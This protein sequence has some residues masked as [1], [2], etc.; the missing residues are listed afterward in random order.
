MKILLFRQLRVR[1]V[2]DSESG[3]AKAEALLRSVCRPRSFYK[4]MMCLVAFCLSACGP[5]SSLTGFRFHQ[6]APVKSTDWQWQEAVAIDTG[7]GN[8]VNNDT[9]NSCVLAGGGGMLNASYH[10]TGCVQQPAIAYSSQWI[11]AFPQV[12]STNSPYFSIFANTTSLVTKLFGTLADGFLNAISDTT[13][14]S[15]RYAQFAKL[16][17]GD[18]IAVFWN[19]TAANIREVFGNVYSTS[20]GTWSGAFRLSTAGIAATDFGSDGLASGTNLTALCR[21]QIAV[22]GDGSAMVAWCED[23]AIPNSQV[24]YRIYSQGAWSPI[25][26][27][28]PSAVA[29]SPTNTTLYFPGFYANTMAMTGSLAANSSTVTMSAKFFSTA[30]C[31]SVSQSCADVTYTTVVTAVSGTPAAGQF[32]LATD[33]GGSVLMCQT[34]R[35]MMGAVLG[36]QSD[37]GV[38]FS[39]LGI[40]MILDS[41]CNESATSTC[42]G[43]DKC[44]VTAYA[45]RSLDGRYLDTDNTFTAGTIQN[46]DYFFIGTA[47]SSSL[48]VVNSPFTNATAGTYLWAKSAGVAIAGDGYGNYAMARTAVSPFFKSSGITSAY[49]DYG[50]ML[51]G[52]EYA[53]GTTAAWKKTYNNASSTILTRKISSVPSCF[54]SMTGDYTACS[55]RSPKFVMS[56][57]GKGLVFFHQN[58]PLSYSATAATSRNPN[59]LWVAAYSTGTGFASSASTLDE[60][61]FCNSSSPENDVPV[62][63]TGSYAK[64]CQTLTES[65]TLTSGLQRVYP[66]AADL[67]HDVPPIAARMNANGSAIVAFH[68]KTNSGTITSPSC[69]YHGVYARL[70]DSAGGFGSLTQ[71]D[72]GVGDT[73]HAQAAINASGTA[74]V[75]WEEARGSSIF[76]IVREYLN[77]SWQ[78]AKTLV[79]AT[80][81]QTDSMMPA[82]EI[83]DSGEVL[84]SFTYG[85]GSGARRQYVRRLVFQ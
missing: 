82:V 32:Q 76:L 15:A 20:T 61:T 26:G 77:G 50:R 6:D 85:L 34:L 33:S 69:T 10:A 71:L 63:E 52:H 14:R 83:G 24:K 80:T 51:V 53:G 28:S 44:N 70:Y 35:N 22:S 84:V 9:A 75:V 17:G 38:T 48:A 40:S 68:K 56:D 29:Q 81:S 5:A 55:V 27:N 45:N 16:A 73:M 46:A 57:A 67:D 64:P 31:L 30:S 4:G 25:I 1:K 42:A 11:V 3:E 62:C 79:E 43:A 13:A 60:D 78:T 23:S 72:T 39:D 54:D 18:V 37:Q 59:R 41:G 19:D 65:F 12:D 58:Q 7:T 49:V 66:D 21:P 2:G 36:T 8:L 47:S 74:A